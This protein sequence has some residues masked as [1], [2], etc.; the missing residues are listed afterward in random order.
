[1]SDLGRVLRAQL[2]RNAMH[3]RIGSELLGR[4]GVELH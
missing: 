2:L 3:L 1:M 4:A